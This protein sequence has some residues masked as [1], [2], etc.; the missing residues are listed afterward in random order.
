MA[1]GY[2]TIV[3]DPPWRYTKNPTPPL[4]SGGRGASAEHIYPTMT[5]EEI[6]ALPVGKLAAAEAHL[7]MW[8]TNPVLIGMRKYIRGEIDAPDIARAWGFEPKTLLTW[9]KEGP[10]GMGFYFRGQ[11]E[12]VIF[13]V[14]GTL[15]ID[16]AN[17]LRNVFFAPRRGHSEKP[18]VFLDLVEQVSPEPRLELFARRQRLGW[19]TYGDEALAH[20]SMGDDNLMLDGGT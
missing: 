17:R 2:G 11:T 1:D 15:G 6:A 3:A 19:D 14:R 8:V 16:A 10:P 12:H 5:M 7:Y 13:A 9:V 20:V 4:R 18:E